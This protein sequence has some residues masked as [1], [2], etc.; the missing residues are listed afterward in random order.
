MKNFILSQDNSFQLKST[1]EDPYQDIEDISEVLQGNTKMT[2][3]ILK[4]ANNPLYGFEGQIYDLYRAIAFL[5]I[6]QVNEIV[7]GEGMLVPKR[8]SAT[9][10]QISINSIIAAELNF[11]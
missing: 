9:P 11:A 3:A 7:L 10:P 8:I 5:G 6:G 1:L 2:A 4:V